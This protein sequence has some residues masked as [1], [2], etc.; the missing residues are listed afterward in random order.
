[1][2]HKQALIK[3]ASYAMQVLHFNKCLK[4]Y[5]CTQENTIVIVYSFVKVDV[6]IVTVLYI[7]L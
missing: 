3:P 2:C 4:A 7:S 1:M 6:V 5:N